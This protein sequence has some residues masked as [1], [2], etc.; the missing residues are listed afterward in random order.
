MF[1]KKLYLE[2]I[3]QTFL[4]GLFIIVVATILNSFIPLNLIFDNTGEYY[5]SYNIKVI[6]ENPEYSAK[7]KEILIDE[8]HNMNYTTKINIADA[9]MSMNILMYLIPII[10][11]FLQF[12]FLGDRVACDFYHS[13]P[14]SRLELV[15]S[16]SIS[17]L[18]WIVL[19]TLISILCNG[20]L[21]S[22]V[23][24]ITLNYSLLM[25][26]AIRQI[27]INFLIYSALLIGVSLS[28]QLITS[29]IVSGL[30]LFLPR[31][32]VTMLLSI[33][34]TNNNYIIK[35]TDQLTSLFGNH[36][37]LLT[38]YYSKS[39][40]EWYTNPVYSNVFTMTIEDFEMLDYTLGSY[41]YT[42]ILALILFSIGCF[43]FVKRK[44]EM[45]GKNTPNRLIQHIIRIALVLP[46]MIVFVYI[47]NRNTFFLDAVFP[48]FV[49]SLVI[50]F[51][52][53]LIT[54]RDLKKVLN[55]ALYFPIVIVFIFAYQ[56]VIL[57]GESYLTSPLDLSDI[58]SVKL[59]F[60]PS[61]VDVTSLN[62]HYD[63]YTIDLIS[64]YDFY[65]EELIEAVSVGTESYFNYLNNKNSIYYDVKL[66]SSVSFETKS[67]VTS[68]F[69][70]F[71]E[72]YADIIMKRIFSDEYINK[73]LT[74]QLPEKDDVVSARATVLT[75][76]N[77][78]S[79]ELQRIIDVLYQ[80]Y[81]ALTLEQK[82][83]V[84]YGTDN[85]EYDKSNYDRNSHNL[86]YTLMREYYE[87]NSYKEYELYK[88]IDGSNL[89]DDT[90]SY[91]SNDL[92]MALALY[93]KDNCSKFIYINDL[94][95]K[96][97]KL[98]VD[99]FIET[100]KSNYDMFNFALSG[101]VPYSFNNFN[102][103]SLDDAYN[104]STEIL[105][106][107][108]YSIKTLRFVLNQ[109]LADIFTNSINNLSLDIDYENLY[110]ITFKPNLPDQTFDDKRILLP[111]TKDE[112]E[113]F[114]LNIDKYSSI[115]D[116][117]NEIIN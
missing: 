11:I 10:M 43:T 8:L 73:T 2:G 70:Q 64:E 75:P 48:V 114:I 37:N 14:V 33:I 22:F 41:I 36:L 51:T 5:M 117:R 84:A 40:D 24:D 58:K 85:Y 1:N 25:P 23:N 26:Y 38:S 104:L 90:S 89:L 68:R 53:E 92:P 116:G 50:Y 107:Y 63:S 110:V 49:F 67:K 106:E 57:L 97:K 112:F 59:D 20:L 82:L 31:F 30:I 44:S 87:F 34:N 88:Y 77:Y 46:I 52:Y 98:M 45:A 115:I 99:I 72:E 103:I 105:R 100:N 74:T 101:E 29:I 76:Y 18:T 94:L 21:F 79:D 96:T 80:E 108:D 39:F 17:A 13:I 86:G 60:N 32:A 27:L 81:D 54:T 3:R 12:K 93:T 9:N 61:H 55:S 109:E 4:I 71:K 111:L 62:N 78:S 7:M 113:T 6:Q 42:F 16:Y 83:Q 69:I 28:S 102:I 65:D 15:I 35:G 91:G 66:Y 95:P 56:G 47:A 19:S